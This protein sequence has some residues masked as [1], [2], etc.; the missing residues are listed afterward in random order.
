MMAGGLLIEVQGLLAGAALAEFVDYF[1]PARAASK[2]LAS[3]YAEVRALRKTAFL[4]QLLCV[5][6]A[7]RN[8]RGRGG[9][10]ATRIRALGRRGW[11]VGSSRH[12]AEW[13]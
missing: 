11:L 10:Q 5:G 12:T 9:V 4:S 6:W 7:G 13:I 8:G 3:E 1:P 2:V